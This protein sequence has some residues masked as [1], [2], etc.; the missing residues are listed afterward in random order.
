MFRSQQTIILQDLRKKMVFLTGPR[1]VG[2]TWLAQE[3]MKTFKKPLY[4]NYDDPD[5]LKIIKKRTW[6]REIDFIIFDEIHKMPGW[7]NYLKGIYDTRPQNLHILVT[8]SAR[9][10]TFR[11]SGDS[12]AGRYFLHHLLPLSLAEMNS[13]SV[14]EEEKLIQRGGF[15]EA[16]LANSDED[17]DR[18]RSQ[19]LQGLIRFDVLD[20]ERIHDFKAIQNVLEILRR[21]VGSTISY[22]SIAEDVGVALNTVKKYIQILEDLH[23]VFRLIPYSSK[24]RHSLKKEPK[25]YFYDTGAVVGDVGAKYEN[26]VALSLYKYLLQIADQKGKPVGLYYLKTKAGNEVDFC[27]VIDDKIKNIIEAKW[28]DDHLHKGLNYFCKKYHLAGIQLVHH[29]K[30]EQQFENIKIKDSATYLKSLSC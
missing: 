7:K 25:L 22:Q 27:L 14:A 9:L 4:L 16:F 12:L 6:L 23:I 3:L 17:A 13:S 20:F 10:D 15:P 1:Q 28:T 8:G 2:K 21:S 24:I 18:W 29:L 30:T 26:Y 19:Y 5:H 11:Y